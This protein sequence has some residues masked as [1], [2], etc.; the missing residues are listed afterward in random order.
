MNDLIKI[1][2]QDIGTKCVNS[3]KAKEVYEYLGVKTA[4]TTW[5]NRCVDKYDFTEH[6]DFIS[7]LKKSNG[8][9]P[10]KVFIVTLEMAKELCMIADTPK[11][12]ETR[13][14][15]I[16]VE[17]QSQRPLTITEQISLIAKG[18]QEVNNRIDLLEI[19][20]E[21][22][23]PLT[24]AQKHRIKA[25][26]NR[27]VYQLKE[28][29]NLEQDFIPKCYSRVWKKIKNHFVVSSYMEIPKN[30]FNEL[31]DVVDNINISDV[32]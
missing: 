31:L 14:Y 12:K 1:T 16:A 29:H 17:K 13:K 25:K 4:F 6:E 2:K 8:G 15:F 10:E 26:V 18:H 23:I 22:D 21:N 19:K 5:F 7:Y 20:I 28:N 30:K 9:R 32:I 24:S 3:V 11:G 27:L